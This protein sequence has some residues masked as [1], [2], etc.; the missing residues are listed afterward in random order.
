MPLIQAFLRVRGLTLSPEKT[1][2]THINDGFDFLGQN[3][4]KYKGKLLIKPSAKSQQAILQKVRTI[5]KTEG[6]YLSAHGLIRKLNPVIRGWANYHRHIVSKQVFAQVDRQIHWAL[7]RWA[8][9][10]HKKKSAGWIR[11]KY[12]D[13]KQLQRNIFHTHTTND[14]GVR[15]PL[16]LFARLCTRKKVRNADNPERTRVVNRNRVGF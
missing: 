16:R 9:R 7:W 4:R 5:I 3:V 6:R 1:T 15:I 11:Q 13:D 2:I 14:K 10:R 12:F 8:K